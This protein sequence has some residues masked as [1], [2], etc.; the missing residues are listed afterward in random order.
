MSSQG[1]GS[2]KDY[3]DVSV[4]R[5]PASEIETFSVSETFG[6]VP[7]TQIFSKKIALEDRRKYR[8]VMP[9]EIAYNPFLLWTGAAGAN[10]TKK[11]VAVS[12]AYVVLAPRSPNETYFWH[13]LFRSSWFAAKVSGLARGTVT[14]RR[15]ASLDDILQLRIEIPSACDRAKVSALLEILDARFDC[16]RRS[17]EVL[18]GIAQALYGSWFVSFDAVRAKAEGRVPH[19][20][21]SSILE[22][23]PSQLEDSAIG[24]IPKGWRV[25]SL[26]DICSVFDS[27]R[28]PLSGLEREKRPGPY[29][30]FGAAAL[31]GFV[32]DYIF[33][34]TYVLL[35]EDGSVATKDGFAL[36][37][38]VWGKIWVNNHAHVLQGANGVS[39]EQL[40]LML[41]RVRIGEYIT[42]AVQ[43]K[44]SQ[45]S[46]FRIPAIIAPPAI[47][48]SFFQIVQPIFEAIRE[49]YEAE[50]LLQAF[51]DAVLP[52]MLA[53]KV[54]LS[55]LEREFGEQQL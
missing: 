54:D 30:Y 18:E 15:V 43:A 37:Q 32:D 44:L 36:T 52:S 35:A 7:Q 20:A 26:R 14:R 47:T 21:D 42:G 39:T 23:L 4:R 34:G 3:V 33:D 11:A 25:G 46:M 38:Y 41:K 10:L 40:L 17:N 48:H 13:H 53:G 45:S 28:I 51:Q 31:M 12:P 22:M 50:K 8:V 29:P 27:K 24:K 16:I 55:R 9:G 2:L 19:G 1:S 49:N 5:G 6:L